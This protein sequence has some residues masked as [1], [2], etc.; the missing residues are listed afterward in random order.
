MLPNLG[1]N[2]KKEKGKAKQR[3]EQ[4]TQKKSATRKMKQP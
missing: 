1:D 3:K 4:I 2:K